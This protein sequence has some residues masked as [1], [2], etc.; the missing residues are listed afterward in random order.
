V[1]NHKQFT[2]LDDLTD[3]VFV[4]EQLLV[5]GGLLNNGLET[6]IALSGHFDTGEQI[7]Q[8][9]EENVPI[10]SD[11]LGGIEVSEGSQ[12][13]TEL[14]L[15]GLSALERTGYD[16]HGLDGSKTPIVVGCLRE[17]VTA[18]EVK[19]SEL[20][21]QDLGVDETFR[22]QHVFA[23][24]FEIGD[25]DGDGS[26]EGFETLRQLGAAQIT[27]VHGDESAAGRVEV[28]FITLDLEAGTAALD[29]VGDGLELD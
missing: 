15:G 13:N 3:E 6:E 25:H 16:E 11:N 21:S 29:G 22:H 26:E 28:H 14:N 23:N 19:R 9:T 18:K 20:L 7:A 17:Q 10:L 8:Q 4:S 12:Q 27:W 1:T 2:Q 5:L 24:Q